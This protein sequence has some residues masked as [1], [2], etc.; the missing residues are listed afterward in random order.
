[1]SEHKFRVRQTVRFYPSERG[2]S[3]PRGAYIVT[4]ELPERD[5]EFQYRIRSI[6][7][8]HDLA[9]AKANCAR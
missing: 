7:E 8:P 6:V 1:M 5:G 9:A 4:T 2:T 3:A